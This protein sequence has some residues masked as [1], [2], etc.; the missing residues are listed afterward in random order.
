MVKTRAVSSGKLIERGVKTLT[1]KT[2]VSGATRLWNSA[3]VVTKQSVTSHQN[4]CQDSINLRHD[5]F[6][7]IRFKV[8]IK[9]STQELV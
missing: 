8:Y 3:P 9:S 2:C 4:F 1:T 7:V 5:E 6:I